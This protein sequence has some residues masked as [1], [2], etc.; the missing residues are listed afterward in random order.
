MTNDARHATARLASV[1]V[2]RGFA[3]VGMIL[4]NAS[5]SISMRGAYVAIQPALSAEMASL[6]LVALPIALVFIP[7]WWLNRSGR[8]LRLSRRALRESPA[9]IAVIVLP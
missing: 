5:V 4:A 8:F 2:G 9:P 3:I 7:I 6:I 1:D